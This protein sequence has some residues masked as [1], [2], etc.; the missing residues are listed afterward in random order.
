MLRFFCSLVQ[1]IIEFILGRFSS[2]PK[3]FMFHQIDDNQEAWRDPDVCITTEGFIRFVDTLIQKGHRF[4][5]IETLNEFSNKKDV[6]LT[7]DDIFSSVVENAVPY[8]T[9]KGIPFCVFVSEQYIDQQDFVS[10]DQLDLLKK[11]NLCTIGY[12]GK[13]HSIMR[14]LSSTQVREELDGTQLEKTVERS[15]NYFAF[16]YGSVYACSAMNLRMAKQSK[17]KFVF[18]TISVPCSAIWV[19]YF[20]YFLPRIN[21]NE[22]NY[23]R[24]LEGDA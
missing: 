10:K 18:S 5:S 9:K 16:P 8:L 23:K 4:C 1:K 13:S 11:E 22:Q 21:V 15:I 7:F 14:K 2:G 20:S 19:R 6:F 17:Y 24:I 3:I 12:H